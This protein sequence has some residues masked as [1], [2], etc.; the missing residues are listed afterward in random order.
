MK[1]VFKRVENIEGKEQN[2]GYQHFHLFP[3]NFLK[4]FS[5]RDMKTWAF[6]VKVFGE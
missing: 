3:S 5:I 2:A 6:M 4:A 1:Y